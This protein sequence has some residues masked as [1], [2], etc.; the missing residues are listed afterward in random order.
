[1]REEVD[2]INLA[3]ILRHIKDPKRTVLLDDP[4]EM[5]FLSEEE[6]QEVVERA[7]AFFGCSYHLDSSDLRENTDSI[8]TAK[9]I[10]SLLMNLS[11][12]KECEDFYSNF[13]NDS[14]SAA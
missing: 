6:K 5:L 13:F 7:R 3:Y 2:K 14:S 8:D 9:A 11:A 10:Y 4:V 12:E 1:M